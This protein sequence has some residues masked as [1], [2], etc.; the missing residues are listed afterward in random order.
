MTPQTLVSCEPHVIYM[1]QHGNIISV[2]RL[3]HALVVSTIANES[4]LELGWSHS[5]PAMTREIASASR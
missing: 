4:I 3:H 2:C 5:P 1:K